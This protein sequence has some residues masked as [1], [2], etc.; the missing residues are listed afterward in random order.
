[1]RAIV[2]M[3]VILL[4]LFVSDFGFAATNQCCQSSR[5]IGQQDEVTCQNPVTVTRVVGYQNIFAGPK[6][7][8]LKVPLEVQSVSCCQPV[9]SF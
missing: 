9:V 7:G 4:L 6:A 1:M 5:S 3:G 8:W 2:A